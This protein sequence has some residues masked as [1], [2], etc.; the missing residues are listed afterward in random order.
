MILAHGNDTMLNKG[1]KIVQGTIIALVI[2]Y[3]AYVIVMALANSAN[4]F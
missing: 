2:I 3:A 4:Y 1:K